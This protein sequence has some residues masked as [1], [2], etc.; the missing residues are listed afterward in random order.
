MSIA[1]LKWTLLCLEKEKEIEN[2]ENGW[3]KFS[4]INHAI[5]FNVQGIQEANAKRIL[6]SLNGAM[7]TQRHEFLWG[8][9][10]MHN[11]GTLYGGDEE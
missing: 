5:G 7:E 1:P 3:Y 10:N 6:D 9:A 2:W 8:L 4:V 11:Q